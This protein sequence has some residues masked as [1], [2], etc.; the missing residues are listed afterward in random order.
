[1]L[2][3][4][5]DRY[6]TASPH[7]VAPTD[8]MTT[9]HHLMRAHGFRHLPV[10]QAGALIGM[11]S[12]RDLRLIEA[13]RYESPDQVTVAEAMTHGA[14]AFSP[15]TPL[16]EVIERMASERCD[17]VA[18][19]GKRGV[20]GIFTASDALRALADLLRREAA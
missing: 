15:H 6:M 17:A 5:V 14:I 1:M 3:P 18:V 9:A 12:D 7:T 10:V 11:L 4:P 20:E 8:A 19:V 2:M 13:L 16:D